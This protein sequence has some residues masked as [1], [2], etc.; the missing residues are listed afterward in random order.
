MA[1]KNK[2]NQSTSS[3]SRTKGLGI[4]G[5]LLVVILPV[6]IIAVN[7]VALVSGQLASNAVTNESTQKMEAIL[8]AN[9]N[10]VNGTLDQIRITCENLS[11]LV[12]DTYQTMDMATYRNIFSST[13]LN[14]DLI[15]GSG[16]WFEPMVYTG[17]EQYAE[18][19]YVGPYW[20]R[21]GSSCVEDW[22][23][24]NAEYDYFN[25]K[26]YM[27]TTSMT[28]VD[29]T[30]T[31]PY[32]DS[33]SGT[34]MASC[35]APILKNG[36]FLGCI[37][38]DISLDT[39][40]QV[41]GS[42]QIGRTGHAILT[43]ADG[44]YIYCEDETKYS[45]PVNIADDTDD[46]I[47]SI[48]SYLLAKDAGETAY[49]ANSVFFTTIPGVNWK[50]LIT[51]KTSEIKEAA[52]RMT[53]I[54]VPICI[55]AIIVCIIIIWFVAGG[56]AKP[57]VRVKEFA[58]ELAEGNFTIDKIRV[59]R[60]D[61]IG[62]MSESLNHMYEANSNVIRN[63]SHGSDNVSD[64]STRLNEVATDLSA[65]FEVIRDA[66][67]KV[68]DA[69]TN[70][71]AATEEVSASANEVNS[72]VQQLAE[73]TRNTQS[74]VAE[75]KKRAEEIERQSRESC[76]NAITIAKQRGHELEAASKQAA[77]I[78]EIGT[79]ADSISDIASQINLLSLNA[80]IEAA[81]A[82]EHGRGFAVVASEINKLASET[83]EAVTQIQETIE[84]IQDAFTS[85]DRSSGE[86]LAFVKDTVAPDYENFINVGQQYGRDAASFGE[87]TEQTADMVGYIRES[88][89]QV[90]SAVASIAESATETAEES[91]A[92]TETVGEVSDMIQDI[93]MMA[94]NQ[95][96]VSSNL[97]DIVNNF[98]LGEES[99][100]A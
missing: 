79:L 94:E 19:K 2:M 61:E 99:F 50:L 47:N 29:A 84:K 11:L 57:I 66:M 22:E 37:T 88:M 23:Y 55:G 13:V 1:K 69:M 63:I 95:Q 38:V 25:Q 81:R 58:A 86:L 30:I 27:D 45:T 67:M 82:G 56:I 35:S 72:S 91:S 64:S 16:I 33:S 78:S 62:Q 51:M 17:D 97:N 49:G 8:D 14:N 76:D 39:I 60:R 96:G 85:L 26:Y 73:D 18:Q 15:L 12:A 83:A 100:D 5:R 6:V 28:S 98:K 52:T 41:I 44:T 92:V 48:A 74:R 70:T 42:I 40:S 36:K 65:R 24:S 31:D 34:I 75:I 89:D 80:S 90:N 54:T 4:K 32:Y 43:M 46:G 7:V 71:G 21:D 9:A 53:K 77:V 20:Y 93:S 3:A 68:N 87:L 59:N 10:S